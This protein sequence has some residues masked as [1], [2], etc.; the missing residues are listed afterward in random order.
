MRQ[1]KTKEGKT[2]VEHCNMR[3]WAS[4]KRGSMNEFPWCVPFQKW[5]MNNSPKEEW[6]LKKREF[7]G[8]KRTKQRG[9]IEIIDFLTCEAFRRWFSKD[10]V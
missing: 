4:A 8:H 6:S 2:I 3:K 7:V 1:M 9:K 10:G 5:M